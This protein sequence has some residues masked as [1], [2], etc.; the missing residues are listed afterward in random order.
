[1]RVHPLILCTIIELESQPRWVTARWAQVSYLCS[2]WKGCLRGYN[3]FFCRTRFLC[4]LPGRAEQLPLSM[5]INVTHSAWGPI[6]RWRKSFELLPERFSVNATKSGN[7][8][9]KERKKENAARILTQK[10]TYTLYTL[11]VK[12]LKG[13]VNS[14]MRLCTVSTNGI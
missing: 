1:M 2:V 10:H 12:A 7:S 6:N 11:G 9:R 13:T 3:L 5:P 14:S 8:R 4:K